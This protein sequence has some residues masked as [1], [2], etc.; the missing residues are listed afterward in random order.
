[1]TQRMKRG[2]S[3][4][5]AG[6][7]MFSLAACS[8]PGQMSEK[9]LEKKRAEK[10]TKLSNVYTMQYLKTDSDVALDS[11]EKIKVIDGQA[12]LIA[13]YWKEI[14]G[15]TEDDTTYENGYN[16][17]KLNETDGTVD[18][19]RTFTSKSNYDEATSTSDNES[20]NAIYPAADGSVWY[21]NTKSHSDW[22][23]ENH[24][25]YESTM[26]LVHEDASGNELSRFNV[27]KAFEGQDLPYVEDLFMD[28]SGNLAMQTYESFRVVDANGNFVKKISI[29]DPYNNQYVNSITTTPSGDILAMVVQY[30][31]GD[32]SRMIKKLDLDS[33][34]MEDLF[35]CKDHTDL[36]SFFG[37]EDGTIYYTDNSGIRELD[38]A[39]G[40]S[41][42]ILNFVNSDINGNRANV[43]GYLGNKRFV[44]TEYDSSYEHMRS[45]IL[46]PASEND[47][48]EKYVLDFAAVYLDDNLQ[49][50]IIDFNK[51][52]KD[53]RIQFIDYSQYNTDDDYTAGTTQLN[54][55]I[56]S[57]KIP[58]MFSLQD[59]PLDNYVSKNLIADLKQYMDK[60]EE[61]KPED[62]IEN[63][64]NIT[65][66]DGKIYSI[67]A[68]YY[69]NCLISSQDYFDGKLTVTMKEFA[70]NR[71]QHADSY[72]F[73]P[74][75]SRSEV[76]TGYN[77]SHIINN[78]F[79][80]ANG[81]M[82]AFDSDDFASWLEIVKEFPEEVDWEE[83]QN[84]INDNGNGD[85]E[86]AMY[87]SGK[88][89]F[90]TQNFSYL[91]NIRYMKRNYGENYSL[92]GY[93]VP[94]GS[95]STGISINPSMEIAVSAKS[96]FGEE[97]WSFVKYLLGKD[98]QSSTNYGLTVR[99]DVLQE[100]FDKVLKEQEEGSTGF[101]PRLYSSEAA[102]AI[103]VDDV[104]IGGNGGSTNSDVLKTT[105]EDLEKIRI[106]IESADSVVRTDKEVNKII[107]E[108]AGAYFS[109]KKSAKDVC[110]I[111]QSR[112]TVYVTEDQ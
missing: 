3:L 87:L 41:K 20:I 24:S 23:D 25:V 35:D 61:F 5:L 33:G 74:Y 39:T 92:I 60:D 37:G 54:N 11:I 82:G 46:N 112:V 34:K 64:L 71:K 4:L 89:M 28:K 62:Y 63:I 2:L 72:L 94:E 14:K 21:I 19:L 96:P 16:L 10:L 58:D 30:G 73:A 78:A 26:E 80:K 81:G 104:V 88:I 99:K 83:Y 51:Q 42:E 75:A 6:A 93:P 12:Y 44:C 55:D 107:E 106:L 43:A 76:L 68:A 8:K 86:R 53:Y 79:L 110:S 69:I 67:V 48:V 27:D 38:F 56:I 18:L 85:G 103:A 95:D 32:S 98:F 105:K 52:S 9:E 66:K 1:M 108:E 17:L 91:N 109:G 84:L 57:G 31:D 15:Q 50:A 65:E 7:T 70:E 90:G 49:N 36:Y 47:V 59:L 97:A 22:S 111:I 13:Y 40:E 45:A 102:P 100:Q 29:A 77:G 101:E